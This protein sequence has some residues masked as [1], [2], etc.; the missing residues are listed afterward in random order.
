MD[1]WVISQAWEV[2]RPY[3]NVL[4]QDIDFNV[5]A[6]DLFRLLG[7]RYNVGQCFL[8]DA[9]LNGEGSNVHGLQ[10]P[11]RLFTHPFLIARDRAVMG[12]RLQTPY[13]WTVHYSRC[14]EAPCLSRLSHS[15]VMVR[16]VRVSFTLAWFTYHDIECLT[17]YHHNY[18]VRKA[19]GPNPTRV[20]YRG[21]PE[22]LHVHKH[23]LVEA[24]LCEFFATE[25]AISQ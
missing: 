11:Q 8:E 18:Y 23:T 10:K 25:M 15:I 1:L 3:R 14:I 19:S 16:S 12:V 13:R 4:G 24:A 17:R 22:F 5:L 6:D 20:Y 9:A 2:L 21:V 7:P